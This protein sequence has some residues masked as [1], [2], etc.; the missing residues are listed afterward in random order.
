MGADLASR[1]R[2]RS[3]VKQGLRTFAYVTAG[4][5]ASFC[6][7]SI[8]SLPASDGPLGA[9]IFAGAALGVAAVAPFA[10]VR[11]ADSRL[12]SKAKAA[13]LPRLPEPAELASGLNQSDRVAYG[14]LL[15]AHAT[16]ERLVD[17]GMVPAGALTGIADRIQ[18]LGLLLG[19]DSRSVRVGGNLSKELRARIGELTNQLV[20]LV[21]LIVDREA[22]ALGSAVSLREAIETIEAYASAEEELRRL[23]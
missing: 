9:K 23:T 7:L 3:T 21:D 1:L 16:A 17:D 2:V 20:A 5:W 15:N 4:M 19:A 8:A 14:K 18:R 12:R 11:L 10:A 22:A 6:A 13:F